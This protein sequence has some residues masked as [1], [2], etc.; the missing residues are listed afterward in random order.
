VYMYT[1][2]PPADPIL[3]KLHLHRLRK[4]NLHCAVEGRVARGRFRLFEAWSL[5]QM[6]N[7]VF[8]LFFFSSKALT[9]HFVGSSVDNAMRRSYCGGWSGSDFSL[10]CSP[11]DKRNG[12]SAGSLSRDGKSRFARRRGRRS[13]ERNV[14]VSR[15][16]EVLTSSGSTSKADLCD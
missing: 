12:P 15:V 10:P 16:K 6:F 5:N 4:R 13:N 2:I 7:P 1:M 9:S 8:F 3:P 11:C 14:S